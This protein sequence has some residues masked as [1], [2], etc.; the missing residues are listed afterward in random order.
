M[1]PQG[2]GALGRF[3]LIDLTR[4]RS[5]PTC[6]RQL[7]DFGANVIKV[8]M[9]PD[10]E[11]GSEVPQQA[12]N[13]HPTSIPT[14][15]FE[16]SDGL[17]NIATTGSAIWKRFCEAAGAAHLTAREEYRTA[18][19]RSANRDAL[20]A[21]IAAILRQ[22]ATAEWLETL[23]AAGVPCGSI[24]TI[25]EV[26]AD[27]Q[28]RHLGIAQRVMKKDG[29]AIPLVG[30]PVTLART[31]AAMRRAAPDIGEH[32]DEILAEFGYGADEIAGFR[33]RRLI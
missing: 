9:P 12:G 18:R 25:D 19:D 17:I 6:L 4:V 21:E 1:S 31:P 32:T 22:R 15:V 20:N 30:Q 14:G 2:G 7:A 28:V 33:A 11:P 29:T 8:E 24:N 13:N 5:G 10:A 27:R 23:N 3:T 26:F 16:T